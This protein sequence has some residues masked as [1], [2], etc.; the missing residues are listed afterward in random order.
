[1]KAEFSVLDW[2]GN[3]PDLNP[4][5]N[6]WSYMK[7]KLKADRFNTTSLPKLIFAIKRMWVEDMPASYFLNLAHSMP[8]RLKA[9]IANKGQMIKYEICTRKIY[10]FF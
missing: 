9:V 1:M 3:S 6:C 10:V 8:R 7:Q 4:I 2:P 5:E